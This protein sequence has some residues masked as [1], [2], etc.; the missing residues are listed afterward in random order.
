MALHIEGDVLEA[1]TLGQLPEGEQ[2]P[3]ENHL[4]VCAA[5]RGRLMGVGE[6][7]RFWEA[8]TL[9]LPKSSR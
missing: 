7:V 2:T 1:F 8:L 3:V 4:I 9:L 6:W 5:C